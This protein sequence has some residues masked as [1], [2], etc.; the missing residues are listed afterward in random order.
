MSAGA[1]AGF[2]WEAGLAAPGIAPSTSFL[3][4][5][6][7]GPLPVTV[8]RSIPFC[9]ASFLARGEALMAGASLCGWGLAGASAADSASAVPLGVSSRIAASG[10]AGAA[11]VGR[12]PTSKVSPA[13]PTAAIGAPTGT[14]PPT[15]TIC[16]SNTPSS[17]TSN[18]MVALSVSIS[19][20]M[21]PDSMESPSFFSQLATVPTVMVSLSLGM[22]IVVGI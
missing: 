21:S 20:M 10:S 8:A 3:T 9:V 12:E 18:S 2:F 5:R 22:S 6:P 16:L 11:G 19:A 1:D 4:M 17:K 13:S 7:F 15:G 14:W